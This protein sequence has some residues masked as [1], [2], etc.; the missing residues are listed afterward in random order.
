MSTAVRDGWHPMGHLIWLRR[1]WLCLVMISLATSAL[2]SACGIR[3]TGGEDFTLLVEVTSSG[4]SMA[5]TGKVSPNNTADVPI[6]GTTPF[7]M[8]IQDTREQC[9]TVSPAPP[10]PCFTGASATVTKATKTTGILTVCLGNGH[11]ACDSTTASSDT[12]L[13]LLLF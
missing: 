13:V 10:G 12:A 11:K 7:S 4:S 5:F 8:K 6:S 9:D 3:S 2:L 1:P